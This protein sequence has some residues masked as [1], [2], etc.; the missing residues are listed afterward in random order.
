M[1]GFLGPRDIFRNPD[2]LWRQFEPTD[3]DAPFDLVLS[4]SGGDFAV[5]GMHFKL[6][7]Y[8]HQSAGAIQSLLNI[9]GSE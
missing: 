8:E 6:G 9:L 1:R 3:G 7:L 4:R 5:M 2:A